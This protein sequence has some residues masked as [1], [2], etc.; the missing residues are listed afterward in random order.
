MQMPNSENRLPAPSRGEL[1]RAAERIPMGNATTSEIPMARAASWRLGRMRRPT[2]SM[3]GSRLRMDRP[4][5]PWRMR[6]IQWAY[7]RA[8]GRSRPS[9]RRR[10]S[11]TPASTD[12]AIMTSMGSPG[13]RWISMNTPAET[14]K[15]TG[16]VAAIR[17]RTSCHIRAAYFSHTSRNR[18]IPTGTG[19]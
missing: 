15:S 16:M 4:K 17:C 14:R 6:P 19:S 12:S 5:S 13:V 8:S 3:T 2:F 7:C 10:V 9:S 1:R 18:I 11:L